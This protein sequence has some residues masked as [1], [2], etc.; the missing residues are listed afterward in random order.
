MIKDG[1]T[2][3]EGTKVKT[4]Y[5]PSGDRV[6]STGGCQLVTHN[7]FHGDHDQ[8]WILQTKD[9][10]ELQRFNVDYLESIEW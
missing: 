7:T 2:V 8:D 4:V 6:T 9:G 1:V 5:F 10:K 3:P